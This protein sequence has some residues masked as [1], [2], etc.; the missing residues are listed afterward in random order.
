MVGELVMKLWLFTK[1][2]NMRIKAIKGYEDTYAVSDDGRVFNIRSGKE[3]NPKNNNG[4]FTVTLCSNKK[5][6]EYRVHRLVY[7]AFVAFLTTLL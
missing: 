6:K 4:Y 5:K 7:Q 1:K 3:L 2:T